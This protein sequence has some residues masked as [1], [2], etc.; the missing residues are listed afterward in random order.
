MCHALL[1]LVDSNEKN[2]QKHHDGCLVTPQGAQYDCLLP[3]VVR[4]CNHQAL[5]MDLKMGEVFPMVPVRDFALEDNIFPRSTS[6]S[7]LYTD[8]ELEG[9]G[10]R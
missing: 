7:L 8:A 10:T 2:W 6:D 9:K 1:H 4:P 5:L 3:K